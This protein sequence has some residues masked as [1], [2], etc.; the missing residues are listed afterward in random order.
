MEQAGA[1]H[2]MCELTHG[3]ARERH[4]NGM[5]TAWA[6]HAMCESALNVPKRPVITTKWRRYVGTELK[7]CQCCNS[8]ELQTVVQLAVPLSFTRT[9]VVVVGINA[10]A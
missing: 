7:E 6:R 1:R 3:M 2:G 4:G 5:G 10:F 8:T 9:L